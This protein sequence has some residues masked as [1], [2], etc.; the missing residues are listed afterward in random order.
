MEEVVGLMEV[1]ENGRIGQVAE[2]IVR[3]LDIEVVII[4][5]L[6]MEGMSVWVTIRKKIFVMEE[7]AKLMED[8]VNGNLGQSVKEIVKCQDTEV[9]IA[10]L[11]LM[12]EL[13]VLV[14]IWMRK[15]AK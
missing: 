9:V 2:G 15:L 4:Q 1:G 11:L 12:E 3:S 10:L 6:K 8:G 5:L 7:D 14:I 13:I